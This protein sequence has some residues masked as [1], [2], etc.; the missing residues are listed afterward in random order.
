M[1]TWSY[2]SE[3]VQNTQLREYGK[4]TCTHI[5]VVCERNDIFKNRECTSTHTH[6]HTTLAIVSSMQP[7]ESNSYTI[8]TE[9]NPSITAPGQTHKHYLI[10]TSLVVTSVDHVWELLSIG[11]ASYQV[12]QNNTLP[13]SWPSVPT[14]YCYCRG[15]CRKIK[16]SRPV[17]NSQNFSESLFGIKSSSFPT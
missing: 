2:V 9:G 1:A 15:T 13:A 16:E 5:Q 10:Y 6:T 4:S 7:S 11:E 8:I 17:L 14:L 3:C 12:T